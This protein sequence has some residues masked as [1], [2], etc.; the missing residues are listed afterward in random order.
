MLPLTPY[1]SEVRHLREGPGDGTQHQPLD[2]AL[3]ASVVAQPALD[4]DQRQRLDP[5]REG[6]FI[7]PFGEQG[8]EGRLSARH[9]CAP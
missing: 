8:H 9:Q 3:E 2:E 4:E 1:G 7:L 5:P 6:V